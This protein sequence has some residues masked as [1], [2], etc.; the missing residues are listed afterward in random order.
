MRLDAVVEATGSFVAAP[1]ADSDQVLL[2]FAD[3]ATSAHFSTASVSTD[4][5]TTSSFS[6]D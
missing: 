3:T 5:E 2:V 4:A 6:G 1:D